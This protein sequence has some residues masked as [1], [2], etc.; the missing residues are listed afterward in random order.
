MAG[1]DWER[2][3]SD[4]PHGEASRF[5]AAGG[6]RWHV[7]RMGQGPTLL[8]VHGTGASTHSWRGLMPLLAA[9]YSVVAPDLPGHGFTQIAPGQGMS[10]PGMSGLLAALLKAIEVAPAVAVGHS[11]G[12]AI[13]ARMALDARI[14]PAALVSLNG[15]FLPFGGMLRFLSP[16]ARL[17]AATPIA[18]RVFAARAEDPKAV[19]RLLA[20]TGSTLDAAGAALYARLVRSPAHVHGALTMMAGWNLDALV[21]DMARL[22]TPLL[23]VAAENDRTVLPSQASQV[24]ARVPAAS[25]ERLPGLGHLAHEEDPPRIAAIIETFASLPLRAP[26]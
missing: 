13:L 8:L 20:G 24:A 25:V 22:S 4:W 11:A 14:A 1:L 18:A 17:M 3:G 2:D 9:R 19:G 26:A 10:L 12:A 23:L 21:A 6:I 16:I 15:A 7:Q 5:V